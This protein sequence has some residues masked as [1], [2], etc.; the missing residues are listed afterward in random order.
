MSTMARGRESSTREDAREATWYLARRARG[1]RMESREEQRGGDLGGLR[2]GPVVRSGEVGGEESW[3]WESSA[4]G[5]EGEEAAIEIKL[6]RS[7]TEDV[8][9]LLASMVATTFVDCTIKLGGGTTVATVAWSEYV[10]ERG[11]LVTTTVL[12]RSFAPI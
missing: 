6:T 3:F 5:V 10:K 11:G 2:V 7:P 9:W 8:R 4:G 12:R 1:G